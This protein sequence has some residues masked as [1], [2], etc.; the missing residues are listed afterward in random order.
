MDPRIALRFLYPLLFLSFVGLAIA[1][2]VAQWISANFGFWPMIESL[3][4]YGIFVAGLIWL[5]N[6]INRDHYRAEPEIKTPPAMS[7]TALILNYMRQDQQSQK[8]A[9]Y[10]FSQEPAKP[11]DRKA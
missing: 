3:A 2:S 1:Q 11:S 4:G 7:E 8:T 10:E 5:I 9:P 6:K